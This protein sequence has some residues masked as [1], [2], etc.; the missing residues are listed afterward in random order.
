MPVHV[1]SLVLA[2][3][4]IG[5]SLA[6]I[7]QEPGRS[8]LAGQVTDSETGQSLERAN[9]F[10]ASTTVGTSTS[11]KGDFTLR[12]VPTG[13]YDLV[14]SLA[15][16]ER[17][18]THVEALVPESLYFEIKMKPKLYEVNEVEIVGKS[19]DEWKG[20]LQ[21]FTR[22]FLGATDHS[23]ECTILNPEVLNFRVRGDTLVATSDSVLCIENLA[24]GYRLRTELASFVWDIARDCGQYR[25][26]TRFEQLKATGPGESTTWLENR[27]RTFEGSL[28]HFLRALYSG[29]SEA[30]RFSLSTGSFRKLAADGGHKV[31]PDE[32]QIEP[33][34]GTGLKSFRFSGYLRVDYGR[35]RTEEIETEGR[36]RQRTVETITELSPCSIIS[37][38]YGQAVIDSL[39]NLFDP[40]SIEVTGAWATDRMADMLP[41]H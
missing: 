16:Y 4:Q 12:N 9:V 40:L 10:L 1:R 33:L 15:G 27:K 5:S 37:M 2:L 23:R 31:S 11:K 6:L 13:F 3:L 28:R 24:L 18:I 29:N 38:R 39:G 20:H 21:E 22:A 32:L 7:A 26:Y 14:V 25:A 35:N 34:S 19:A 41:L 17:H 8:V 36:R 30:E